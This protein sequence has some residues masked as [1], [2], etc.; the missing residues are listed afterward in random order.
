MKTEKKT[1]VVMLTIEKE[2]DIVLVNTITLK[3]SISIY[4]EQLKGFIERGSK[5]QHLYFLSDDEIKEGDWVFRSDLNIVFKTD[6]ATKAYIS[7]PNIMG[8]EGVMIKYC[9]KIIAST[10]ELSDGTGLGIRLLP[11]PSN[12]FIQKYVEEYNKGN[13]ITEVMVEY[14]QKYETTQEGLAGFPEDTIT[15]W[16]DKLKTKP[17]NTIIISSVEETWDDLAEKF[18]KESNH[19]TIDVFIQWLKENNYQVPKQIK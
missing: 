19:F 17:D 18:S 9:K 1:Q 8:T 12:S 11:R 10:D 6:F 5:Y 4:P 3:K 7:H 16:V 2:S 14:E 13:I 15:W